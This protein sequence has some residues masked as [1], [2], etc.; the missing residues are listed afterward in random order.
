MLVYRLN[1][2]YLKRKTTVG[3]SGSLEKSNKMAKKCIKL[4]IIS[5]VV[6]KMDSKTK[7]DTIKCPADSHDSPWVNMI[8]L[9]VVEDQQK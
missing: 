1:K 8:K 3:E 7:W 5:L 9:Y 6:R 2:D 4:S